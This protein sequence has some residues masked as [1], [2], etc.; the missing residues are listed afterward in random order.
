MNSKETLN[1]VK[2]LLGLE[3]KL[4][5]MKLDNGTVLEAEMFEAGKDVFIVSEEEKVPLP[6]GEYILEN[7][8]ILLVTEDGIISEIKEAAAEEEAPIEE[9]VTEPEMAAETTPKKVVESISKEMFF[10]EIEKLRNEIAELKA[11]K[12]ELAKDEVVE[13]AKP[14]VHNPEAKTEKNLNLYAQK[15][16]M[17]TTDRVFNKLFNN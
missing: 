3:V 5:Q 6:I 16:A 11:S 12:T 4:E 13:E 10:S 7:G 2:T 8:M 9:E 17:T 1:K 15:R 14:I